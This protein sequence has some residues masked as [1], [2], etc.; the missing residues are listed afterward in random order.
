MPDDLLL[1]LSHLIRHPKIGSFEAPSEEAYE[2]FIPSL[3]LYLSRNELRNLP[4]T[5]WN[6]E[7]LGVL[8]LRINKLTGIS[9]AIANLKNLK[10][11]NLATNKLRW[12]PWEL[13]RLVLPNGN[14]TRLNIS[15]NPFVKGLCDYEEFQ[16]PTDPEKMQHHLDGLKTALEEGEIEPEAKEQF[17]WTVKLHEILLQR[18]REHASSTAQN[19]VNAPIPPW[20]QAPVFIASTTV[21]RMEFDGS[22]QRG[23]PQR[24]SST[25]HNVTR[26]P[27]PS[28]GHTPVD[29]LSASSSRVPSLFEL[30]LRSASRAVSHPELL[31]DLLPHDTPAHVTHALDA[32]AKVQQD[33]GHRCSVCSKEYILPRAEWIEYWHYVPDSLVCSAN[34][35]FLPFLRRACSLGCAASVR[36]GEI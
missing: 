17:T 25:P 11:L 10:E 19:S 22:M 7:N 1:P 21:A 24:P 5:I 35:A 14:L 27:V 3:Q 32:M 12:L 29:D 26:F 9:P 23:S 4:G 28:V 33:G 20:K 13:L 6:L 16:F 34:D 18:M 30:S 15:H 2:P 36:G 31:R 8:S